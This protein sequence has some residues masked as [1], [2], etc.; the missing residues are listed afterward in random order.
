MKVKV[1]APAKI[2]LSL[3]VLRRRPDGYHELRSV[4]A[5]PSIMA[6]NIIIETMAV[7]IETAPVTLTFKSQILY[8]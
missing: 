6:G 1:K 3:D 2:N 5:P 7:F 8:Y 4:V